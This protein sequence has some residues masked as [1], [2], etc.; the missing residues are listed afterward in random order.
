MLDRLDRYVLRSFA[1]SYGVALLFIVGLMLVSTSLGQLDD[2]LQS[3]EELAQRGEDGGF[4]GYLA[5]YFLL[6][7]PL[8]FLAMGPF[9]TFFAGLFTALSLRRSHELAPV[10]GAGRSLQRLLLP[11]LAGGLLAGA[12]MVA[13]REA[14]L[15]VVLDAKDR[16]EARVTRG[17]T[18]YRLE[19]RWFRDQPDLF[20]GFESYDPVAQEI[21][22]LT[23]SRRDAKGKEL[24]LFAPRARFEST[25]GSRGVWR[26]LPL[27]PSEAHPEGLAV[28]I[29]QRLEPGE[30]A[31]AAPELIGGDLPSDVARLWRVRFRPEDLVAL[32]RLAED[33]IA[34]SM[35]QVKR[36]KTFYPEDPRLETL[37]L[38]G[39]SFPLAGLALL[40]LGLPGCVRLERG[41]SDGVFGALVLCVGF[42]AVDLVCRDF[43]S[44]RV[45]HALFA[46][47]GPLALFGSLGC[48]R[49][50]A[51]RT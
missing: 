36:L 30:E 24:T 16:T 13:L 25:S 28:R 5:L 19:K 29:H 35:G 51:M 9:V 4:A 12:A 50:A 26:L 21:D 40:L 10:L 27:P 3:Q 46:C 33:P 11:A 41:G 20:V 34:L 32:H 6:Q 18:D 14:L 8:I 42:F 17:I 23:L 49:Y 45:L 31:L 48:A 39:L 2:F 47:F 7:V 37:A 15:E 44:Q 38:Y 22:Q 43:G 1:S